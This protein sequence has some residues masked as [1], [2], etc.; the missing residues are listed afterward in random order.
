MEMIKYVDNMFPRWKVKSMPQT[1]VAYPIFEY[2]YQHKPPEE[3]NTNDMYKSQSTEE[4]VMNAFI[5]FGD[6]NNEPMFVF[7]K[8]KFHELAKW[9]KNCKIIEF[10]STS[11]KA[12]KET[13]ILIVHKKYGIIIVEVKRNKN[14]FKEAQKQCNETLRLLYDNK[15]LSQYFRLD[16][17]RKESIVK[18]VVA[19]PN[20]EMNNDTG[21]IS[22][23]KEQI[24][25]YESF[26]RWWHT[27]IATNNEYCESVYYDLVP[28]LFCKCVHVSA[29]DT[30][31]YIQLVDMNTI[32]NS[33]Q[34][35]YSYQKQAETERLHKIKKAKSQIQKA[36][37]ELQKAES[38]IEK[39]VYKSEISIPQ[40][41]LQLQKVPTHITTAK[42]KINNAE[43][44]IL[45]VKKITVEII[46]TDRITESGSTL[47]KLW[48][49]VKSEQAEVW[50]GK[51]QVIYG[52]YG[53]GK[54]VLIQCKAADLA[55]S[56]GK[57][58]IILPTDELIIKYKMFL[59][60]VMLR[61]EDDKIVL[62]TLKAFNED[63]DH[64]KALAKD[65]HVFVDEFFWLESSDIKNCSE[66]ACFLSSLLNESNKNYVWIVPNLYLILTCVL[67]EQQTTIEHFGLQHFDTK[68]HLK[69]LST[70]LRTTKQIHDFMA[71]KQWQHALKYK[72]ESQSH[73]LLT[74]YIDIFKTLLCSSHGHHI[75]GP[76]VRVFNIDDRSKFFT[77]T[78]EVIKNEVHKH[79]QVYKIKP[80]DMAV[81]VDSTI[82]NNSVEYH[83][84][85]QSSFKHALINNKLNQYPQ[86]EYYTFSSIKDP[87]YPNNKIV[88][89][90]DSSEI[91][92]FEWSVVIH[93]VPSY[94]K[95]SFYE[96]DNSLIASRCKV[97]Y[98]II[99]EN[100]TEDAWP[101]MNSFQHFKM[102]CE[103]ENKKLDAE[104]LR[105]YLALHNN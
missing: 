104:A 27:N 100:G 43:S 12:N 62:V 22:L 39:A 98:I 23:G 75:C 26:S 7:T 68:A 1:Y 37:S 31:T 105:E 50:E 36:I 34:L 29:K 28:K 92:S 91:P 38:D 95:L 15:I 6:Y 10:P 79:C 81:V 21:Y 80:H 48:E 9:I 24:A 69:T 83:D 77:F 20:D 14:K 70:T 74:T 96:G 41:Q 32:Q 56:G 84:I 17:D 86:N 71:Q 97:Q 78:A 46:P 33:L 87:K 61:H 45:D 40:S 59:S 49:Y 8:F 103:K 58:L 89:V 65:S 19:C 99:C 101:H 85:N 47:R 57:V 60:K 4:Y 63:L 51:H 52:P 93:V 5:R 30:W 13:D 64:F 82:E 54:T 88:A 25:T 2:E 55:N 16:P 35:Q 76:P 90:C 44:Q 102:W 3:A 73:E 18:K 72:L 42:S 67:T 53:S 66:I 94:N 11:A